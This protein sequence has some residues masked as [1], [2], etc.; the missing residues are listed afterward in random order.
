MNFQDLK[1]IETPDFYLDLAFRKARTISKKSKS[2]DFL[3][4]TKEVESNRLEMVKSILSENLHK[5]VTSFPSLDTIDPFYLELIRCTLDYNSLKK[6]LGSASWAVERTSFFFR[7]YKSRIKRST[8]IVAAKQL[9]REY[10]GRIS[11]VLKQIKPYLAYLEESRKT[12]KSYPA[13]KTSLPTVCLFGFPNV[14]K[15]TLLARLTQAS[16]EVNAYPFTT[17]TLNLG[18]IK[19]P[20]HEIQVV[21]TPGTLN[22]FEKMN[23]I[24]LQAYL[25]VKYLAKMIVYVFDPTLEYPFEDQKKLLVK[26][27]ESEKPVLLYMS[28][29]DIADKK[30]VEEFKERFP[31]IITSS[32]ELKENLIKNF[33]TKSY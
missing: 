11:S 28:K 2:K 25:A 31:E 8:S 19:E 14:G 1:K 15:S 33:K 23:D 4:K 26:I 21:D 7:F 30:I 6:S 24:E 17:K 12:M 5:I 20:G 29:T 32:E 10:Y 22:R 9:R 27:R 3:Q 13:I 16:P 18:Y